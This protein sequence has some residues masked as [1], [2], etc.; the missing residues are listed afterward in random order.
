MG[1]IAETPRAGTRSARRRG[2]VSGYILKLIRESVGLTQV[3]L[4]EKLTVDVATVQ[5]WES[6]RRSLTA[7]RAD[8]LARLRIRL[9]GLGARPSVVSLLTNAVEADLVISDAVEAGDKVADAAHHSLAATVHRRDL[10]NLITWPFTGIAPSRVAQLPRLSS[11]RGPVAD[12]PVLGADEQARFF[13]H[14]LV[15][16]DACRGETNALL[17]RQAIYLLGFDT[18]ADSAEWLVSEQKR[19]LRAAGRTDHVPSWVAVRSSA[20]ALAQN[21]DRE[22][23]H[24]FV[25]NGLVSGKQETAN[26][27]YWAY[28]VGEFPDVHADDDFMVSADHHDWPGTR[29]FE[30]LLNRVHPESPHLDLNVH[31]LWALVSARPAVLNY[32]PRLRDMVKTKTEALAGAPELTARASQEVVSV[33]YAVRLAER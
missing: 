23:L 18:R 33:A 4:A 5:G 7:L 24:A 29:L 10:T 1:S 13:D 26:L 3:V 2:I 16:S 22:P 6:G 8:E 28:W 27:N 21:G 20:I 32:L 9:V 19:A 30:H 17:R 15:M 14:L 31:T 12:R 11:R 25:A